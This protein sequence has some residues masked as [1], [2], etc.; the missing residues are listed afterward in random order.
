[1]I[2]FKKGIFLPLILINSFGFIQPSKA[3]FSMPACP[4][5]G[6]KT[7][8]ELLSLTEDPNEFE[9]LGTPEKYEITIYEMGLCTSNTSPIIGSSG[10]KI[11]DKSTCVPTM[12]SGINGTKV[13]LAPGNSTEK[14]APLP[15]SDNRPSSGNYKY[16]YILISSEF[17]LKGSYELSDGTTY[18]SKQGEDSYG[19][20]GDADKTLSSAQEHGEEVDNIGSGEGGWSV[21][22]AAEMS[23][24]FD[25]SGGKMSALLLNNCNHV[26]NS[27]NKISSK[28]SNQES[29]SKLLAIFEPTKDGVSDPIRITDETQGIEV[30]LVVKD[31]GYLIAGNSSD[32]EFFGSAPF[33]PQITS[34]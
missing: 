30:K 23:S 8:S 1:M 28:P 14:I 31:G 18:Y 20:F 24:P 9:C 16:A 17:K 2:N 32:I 34:F 11:W 6:T 29:V 27:C 10:S 21:A 4:T 26:T 22:G 19:P 5:S 15:S 7:Y 25:M 3:E 12:S 33:R 13:D